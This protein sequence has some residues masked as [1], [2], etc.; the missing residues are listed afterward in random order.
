M[1]LK[2]ITA[3]AQAENLHLDLY[4]M[5]LHDLFENKDYNKL[6]NNMAERR[7]E[8]REEL[9]AVI[10]SEGKDKPEAAKFN[11]VAKNMGQNRNAAGGHESKKEK[12][13]RPKRKQKHKGQIDEVLPALAGAAAATA[14]AAVGGALSGAGAAVGGAIK[15]ARSVA[16]GATDDLDEGP[17]GKAM[18]AVALLAALWGVNDNMAQSAYD[19]SP[20]LQKLMQ[21]HAQATANGDESNIAQ[22]E[23]RIEQHKNR[24]DIGKGEV[25][26]RDGNPKQVSM[27]QEASSGTWNHVRDQDGG[28][29]LQQHSKTGEYRTVDRNGNPTG[30][31]KKTEEAKTKKV[32]HAKASTT[33]PKA[34]KNNKD[35]GSS[36]HPLRGKLVGGS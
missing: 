8:T 15:G 10:A 11:P 33:P 14:G 31:K 26:D 12:A 28:L 20:Q 9:E 22:L 4:N 24:L 27:Q 7:G 30:K 25:M 3:A 19:N 2:T 6:L 32:P 17:M 29:T 1:E 36:K 23:R 21:F 16:K 18:G 5:N 13:N 35:S 34:K